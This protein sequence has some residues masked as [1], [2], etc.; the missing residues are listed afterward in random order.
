MPKDM[1]QARKMLNMRI[2]V[3]VWSQGLDEIFRNDI[4]ENV[5]DLF[6][7]LPVRRVWFYLKLVQQMNLNNG[8]VGVLENSGLDGGK[9]LDGPEDVIAKGKILY[10][11][12]TKTS[13][14]IKPSLHSEQSHSQQRYRSPHVVDCYESH[15]I[16]Q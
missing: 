12:P 3:D 14:G 16:R 4:R 1:E 15:S 6:C 9:S 5:R 13:Y 11:L 2:K 7:Q 8:R 10:H